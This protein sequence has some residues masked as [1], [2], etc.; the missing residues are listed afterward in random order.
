MDLTIWVDEWQ[1]ECCGDPFSVGSTVSWTVLPVTDPDW[2]CDVLGPERAAA[3]DAVEDHHAA[4]P[5]DLREIAGVVQAISTVHCRFAEVA[6]RD[7]QGARPVP[8]SCVVTEVDR[9]DG[10]PTRRDDL[11]FVGYLVAL[12][13][14]RPGGDAIRPRG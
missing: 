12:E 14:N 3:V 10:R 6:P 4:T 13:A 8:G 9:T 7:P 2:L 1:M 5:D 11:S